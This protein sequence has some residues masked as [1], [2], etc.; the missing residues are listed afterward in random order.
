MHSSRHRRRRRRRRRRP[1]QQGL[2]HEIR[3]HFWHHS[4]PASEL[5]TNVAER[6]VLLWSG[7]Y[8]MEL[9]RPLVIMLNFCY[10]NYASHENDGPSRTDLHT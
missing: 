3:S 2:I 1:G 4:G 5:W 9:L 10:T 7:S 6:S 8:R